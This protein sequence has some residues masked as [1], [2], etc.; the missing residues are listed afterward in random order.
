ML[1]YSHFVAVASLNVDTLTQREIG[2][3]HTHTHKFMSHFSFKEMNISLDSIT[4]EFVMCSHIRAFI[5]PTPNQFIHDVYVCV[6][7]CEKCRQSRTY[8]LMLKF[9]EKPFSTWSNAKEINHG[10]EVYN[11]NVNVIEVCV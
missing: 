2:D 3:S 7:V 5:L 11:V 9:A 1:V 6:C 4:D 10:Y 8:V